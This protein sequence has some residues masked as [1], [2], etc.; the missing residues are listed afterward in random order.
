MIVTGKLIEYLD[1]GKFVCALVTESQPKRLR[2]V[3]QNG[4]EVNLPLSRIVHCSRQTHPTTASRE[5]IAR[6]LRDTTEKRCL[7]MD[8]IN[9]EEIWELTTEDGS[10]TFSPDFLAEL[11]F[12]E[13]ANDDT[14]SAFLRCVFEDKLFFKYKEGLVRANSP[15][16]V[17][18]LIKQLE[19]EAR[20][21]QQIDDGAQ[22]IARIMAN[23]PDT[24]PFSQIEEEILS[25][26]RDYY[27]FAQDA[28]E[29]ETAQK[30]LKTAGLQR[31]H[32]PYHLLVRAGVWAVNENI[33]LLR[34]DLP[35][36]FSLAARQQAEHILQRGQKELF[37]DPGRLDL[38]HL[39]P[40][41]IDGP[42]T[43]DFDDALT[44][45]EQD[46]KYLVGIHISDV[47]HYVR[48]GDPLFAEAMRRGTSIYFPEG[49]IPMLPRH[50]SQGVCSLIQDEIRAAFSFMILLSAEAEVLRVRITPSIIK[51]RRRLTYD[52]VDR[53]LESDPEIRLL[54]MLRQKLR[55]ERI[56]R[57]ALLLPFPDVNIF[58]D[59]HGKVHVNLSKSDTPART[60]VSE[61]MILA[62][63]EAARYVADRMVP[64]LFRS[65]PPLQNRLVHGEDDD[66]F[67]NTL[68][69][70]Q[71]PR[72]ELGTTAKAHSGLGVSH[73]TTITSPIRRLLDL[74]MQHQLNSVVRREE[75]CFT[76][77]MC[78]DFTS[79]ISRV[80]TTVNNVRYLRQKYWLLKYLAERQGQYLDALVIQ[81]GPKRVN[82]LLT[83][84]LMDIDLPANSGRAPGPNS[85]VKVKVVKADPLDNTVRFDW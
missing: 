82:L 22:L 2:L 71:L 29:A 40:I 53:M 25:I 65:Q 10:E 5:T 67:Q 72:G 42:T 11:I 68:Q 21:N 34:H 38:T 15:E 54:N 64:G 57:G 39:A 31:P 76:E 24:G 73:Y 74:V 46:G 12:G 80:L 55:T 84:I 13:Q 7:L 51:V 47:A 58:I 30:I 81:A 62:N 78:R 9:L 32:D 4:R 48:P 35:V 41:T 70:K 50:L 69:R 79:V 8:H 19:K 52:E 27:L 44:I 3:N 43:L 14:V 66:L 61:M 20:R 85:L 1:N 75:P 60:I 37:T 6:Q 26:I 83:D 17:A 23:P 59:S 36:N 45:E 18:Q 77:E 56:N 49:Q 16:K 28:A 33:P 63:R